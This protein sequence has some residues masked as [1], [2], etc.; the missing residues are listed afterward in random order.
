[1]MKMECLFKNTCKHY[2][3]LNCNVHCYPYQTLYGSEKRKSEFWMA[4]DIMAK[5]SVKV[6]EPARDLMIS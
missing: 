1:M 5:M 2:A 6:K 3:T 4:P